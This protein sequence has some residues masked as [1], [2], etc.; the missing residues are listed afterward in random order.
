[1]TANRLLLM[2][3]AA[4]LCLL[5]WLWWPA[6]SAQ[7]GQPTPLFPELAAHIDAIGRIEV[8]GAGSEVLATLERRDSAWHLLERDWPAHGGRIQRLLQELG[9]ARRVEAKTSDA[10]RYARLGVEPVDAEDAAGIELVVIG[11]GIEFRV[12]VGDPPASG[13]GRFVRV[14]DQAQAWRVDRELELPRET[15]AWLDRRLVDRPLAR[16]ERVEVK[17]ASGRAFTVERVGESFGMDGMPANELADPYRGDALAG[18][19]DALQLDDVA[20]DDGSN[21]VQSARFVGVDGFDIT[22]DAWTA[23]TEVWARC[24]AQLDEPRARAWLAQGDAKDEVEAGLQSLR[25]ELSP[26][27]G[28]CAGHA[29]RLPEYKAR[30]LMRTREQ[31][32]AD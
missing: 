18:L 17:P 12:V 11:D 4:L 6:E 2:V 8:R 1:M 29:F 7:D 27:Q 14:V 3:I 30:N 21:P 5:G 26:L 23:G 20:V 31:Y 19:L 32:L 28:R 13:G 9:E 22:I 16:I 25:G 24:S 15:A 10:T